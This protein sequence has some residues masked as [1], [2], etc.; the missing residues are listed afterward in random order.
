MAA[1][2]LSS[3]EVTNIHR[4]GFWLQ[5]GGEELYLPFVEFPWFEHA[6][7]AQL[8]RIE[9]PSSARLYWPALDLDL[10]VDSIRDP[11]SAPYHGASFDY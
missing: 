7:I 1:I 4:D 8:C 9:C 5:V 10:T 2:C 3:A 6:T 11:M